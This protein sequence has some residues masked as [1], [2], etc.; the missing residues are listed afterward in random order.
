MIRTPLITT[1]LLAELLWGLVP[2]SS[3]EPV[4][5]TFSQE[6]RNGGIIFMTKCASC[7]G[8]YA[9]GS[10]KGPPLLHEYYRP[11]HHSDRAFHA[12]IRNG[13]EQHHWTFGQMDP[14]DGISHAEVPLIIKYVRELQEANEIR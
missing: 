5:P 14:V 9:Q 12:A 7:H 11:D 13:S 10:K 1:G 8:F 4:L 6:A 2:A 3:E